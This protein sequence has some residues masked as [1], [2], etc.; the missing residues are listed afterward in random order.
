MDNPP[1]EMALIEHIFDGI[2]E[3]VVQRIE[4]TPRVRIVRVERPFILLRRYQNS[5]SF[6][7]TKLLVG[8][9]PL[10][11]WRGIW[12][13]NYSDPEHY[14]VFMDTIGLRQ[15][16]RQFQLGDPRVIDQIVEFFLKNSVK[17]RRRRRAR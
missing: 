3:Q 15:A 7:R 11:Q 16:S 12:L 8:P 14:N 1:E 10:R 4:D 13:W 17:K 5:K 6:N 2:F 9:T